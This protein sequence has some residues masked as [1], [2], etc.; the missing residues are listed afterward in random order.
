V[1][2]L[3]GP[4]CAHLRVERIL[5]END[6]GSFHDTWQCPACTERFWPSAVV[7]KFRTE[8][9][10]LAAR[11]KELEGHTLKLATMLREAEERADAL[12]ARVSEA[13][14]KQRVSEEHYDA[15]LDTGYINGYAAAEAE[16]VAWLRTFDADE[17]SCMA[18]AI[19]QGLHRAHR[20]PEEG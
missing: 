9:D 13:E 20:K 17:E 19:E 12:A 15:L 6:D 2:D 10:A 8:R 11:E 18:D 5:H 1:S 3:D 4:F 7:S 16:I 14:A